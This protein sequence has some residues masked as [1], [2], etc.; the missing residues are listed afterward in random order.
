VAVLINRLI[1]K[2]IPKYAEQLVNDVKTAV[3]NLK[4]RLGSSLATYYPIDQNGAVPVSYLWARTIISESPDQDRV[5]VEIPIIRSMWLV[6]KRGRNVALRWA[7]NELGRVRT[8][9]VEIKRAD[10]K[11]VTVRRPLLEV[12][13]PKSNSEVSSGTV[14]R[15][16]VTCP[17]TEYTMPVTAVRRQLS[18]RMGGTDDARLICI[19]TTRHGELGRYYRVADHHD[20]MAFESARCALEAL[21][22]E[23]SGKLTPIPDE[24]ISLDEI[25]RISVPLY[26]M[27]RW[28]DLFTPRQLLALRHSMDYMDELSRHVTDQK[29][30]DYGL[31]FR[32]CMALLL[33]KLLDM[34]S[35]LCVWQNHAGDSRPPLWPLG[36]RHGI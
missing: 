13:E 26:G 5:P 9:V 23:R 11:D 35:A 16:A 7:V 32:C 3:E 27:K 21:E 20:Y 15:G 22:A 18:E 2:Y 36:N 6:K 14:A 29:G 31:A 8:Q 19:V 4:E 12:F 28:R 30:A 25:R 24:I 1:I 17:V 34:N 10:G 33:D